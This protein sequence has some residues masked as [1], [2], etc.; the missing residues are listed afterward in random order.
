MSD[1]VIVSK[2][3]IK[4]DFEKMVKNSLECVSFERFELMD[5]CIYEKKEIIS[6]MI[7]SLPHPIERLC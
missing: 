3:Y 7:M 4:Q 5:A 1:I 6:F 2:R